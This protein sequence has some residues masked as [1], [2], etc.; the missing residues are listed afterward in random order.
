[1]TSRY[2]LN[3]NVTPP[4]SMYNAVMYIYCSEATFHTRQQ[5]IISR[6]YSLIT[7]VKI[8]QRFVATKSIDTLERQFIIL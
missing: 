3:T 8:L 7:F 2:K 1:M 5:S 6:K 4:A